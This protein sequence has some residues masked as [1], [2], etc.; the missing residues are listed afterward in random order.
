MAKTQLLDE[1]PDYI[2]VT[3]GN[4]E[5]MSLGCLRNFVWE[6]LVGSRRLGALKQSPFLSQEIYDFSAPPYFV[7]T[8]TCGANC[9]A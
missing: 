5:N 9:K 8:I 7:A 1:Y 4:P 6:L 2:G 3:P